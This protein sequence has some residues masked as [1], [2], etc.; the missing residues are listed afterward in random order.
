[1]RDGQVRALSEKTRETFDRRAVEGSGT[2]ASAEDQQVTTAPLPLSSTRTSLIEK[3]SA[4]RCPYDAPFAWTKET[5]S[6]FKREKHALDEWADRLIGQ[7]GIRIRFHN[8]A[9]DALQ[10]GCQHHH[11]TGI[12]SHTDNET[13]L[14]LIQNP[15]TLPQTERHGAQPLQHISESSAHHRF[16]IDQGQLKSLVSQHFGFETS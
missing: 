9:G 4:D 5:R 3:L 16:R 15:S 6:R 2:L 8:Y 14:P 7:T 13:C 1:M 10:R 12:P 11:R